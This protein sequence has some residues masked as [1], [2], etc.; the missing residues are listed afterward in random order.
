MPGRLAGKRALV[1]LADRYMGPPI[2]ERFRGEGADVVADTGPLADAA[3]VAVLVEAAGEIDILIA[4][5]AETPHPAPVEEIADEDWDRLF[6][7]M[8]L[9]LMRIVRAVVPGMKARGTGKIIA[10][11]SAAPLRGIPRV[12]AYCAA[13][14]AQNAF[15]RATGLELA[16]D[17]IQVNAIAQNYVANDDYYPQDF[18]ATEKFQQ[19]LDRLV[20][21]KRVVPGA[22]TAELALYLAGSGSTHIVGQIIPFAGGWTTTTG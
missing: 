14:G 15:I 19:H 18:I 5:T 20:P 6:D 7:R 17:N 3:A 21:T 12:A 8:V 4:N 22:E 10:V 13:R 16:R 9:P 1:T 11:T 2:V